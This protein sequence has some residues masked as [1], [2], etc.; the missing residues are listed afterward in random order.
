MM[1]KGFLGLI[2]ALCLTLS[3][4]PASA[5]EAYVPGEIASALLKSAFDSGKIV[6]GDI[7]IALD[8]DTAMLTEG[9][10]EAQAQLD[11]LLDVIQD[12]EISVGVGKLEGGL[13]LEL[14]ASLTPEGTSGVSIS[15][16]ADVTLDGISVESDVIAGNKVTATWETLLALAGVDE[17]T[18]A[19]ILSL[20]E[21]D[22]AT[23]AAEAAAQ[24]QTS[25]AQAAQL[26]APYVQTLADF[27]ASL[28]MQTETGVAA[29]ATHPAAATKITVTFT[30]DDVRT[31]CL[32]LTDQLEQD[33]NLVPMLDAMLAEAAASDQDA[34]TDTAALCDAIREELAELTGSEPYTFVIG[35]DE[36]SVPL[37]AEVTGLLGG[38]V[39]AACYP[40]GSAQNF[41]FMLI[42]IADDGAVDMAFSL[43]GV[44][45][46][47]NDDLK[48][49]QNVD[50]T[51]QMQAVEND[52]PVASM[53][54]TIAGRPLTTDDAQPG[55]SVEGSMNMTIIEDDESAMREM[56]FMN[57]EQAKTA[58]GGEYTKVRTS[59]DVYADDTQASVIATGSMSIEPTE[60]G[61]T[62]LYTISEQ[63]PLLGLRDLTLSA[64]LGARA[65]D[66]DASAALTPLALES[67]TSDDVNALTTQAVATLQ[68][69]LIQ[70]LAVLPQDVQQMIL[71]AE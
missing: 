50:F 40:D 36:N 21:V 30:K 1:K 32:A 29:D 12:A 48:L 16:A 26:A 9:D 64:T 24:L 63:M 7:T 60:D 25:M 14:G 27:A 18:S 59:V 47:D 39:Y 57:T 45:A 10:E 28:P 49:A 71:N 52:V 69:K 70:L 44:F 46:A 34:P 15:G 17:Q 22:W 62:G 68:Q 11:A 2:L 53:D 35:L 58:T 65:Y 42:D 38:G 20:R 51:M 8:V 5:E 13:R 19:M 31:L 43:S 61:F 54:Y 41:S 6:G 66:A 37:F 56:L 4:L 67:A 23:A 33:E 3:L 55:Y